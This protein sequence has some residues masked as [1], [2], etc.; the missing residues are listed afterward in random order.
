MESYL[1]KRL[2]AAVE[3]ILSFVCSIHVNLHYRNDDIPIS[4]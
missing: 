1:H 3:T 4:N 2:A